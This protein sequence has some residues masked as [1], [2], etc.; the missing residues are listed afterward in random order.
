MYKVLWYV[1]VSPIVE[2]I[3]IINYNS[4]NPNIKYKTYKRPVYN[5]YYNKIFIIIIIRNIYNFY[6]KKYSQL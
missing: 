4:N 5:C 2:N 6:K 3:N 1:I